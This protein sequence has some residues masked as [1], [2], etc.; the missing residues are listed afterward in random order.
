MIVI[1]PYETNKL[2][3]SVP[4]YLS[5]LS[6]QPLLVS[7]QHQIVE[8]KSPLPWPPVSLVYCVSN[9]VGQ[10]FSVHSTKV[11]NET[12]GYKRRMI[13]DTLYTEISRLLLGDV[14]RKTNSDTSNLGNRLHDIKVICYLSPVCI[15]TQNLESRTSSNPCQ[16]SEPLVTIEMSHYIY[17]F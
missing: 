2:L 16:S 11:P 3:L 8:I 9:F 13:V 14:S 12:S 6:S 7:L 4:L 5:L 17:K 1:I 10:S 15:K